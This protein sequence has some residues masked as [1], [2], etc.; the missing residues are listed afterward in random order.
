MTWTAKVGV[1]ALIVALIFG[2]GM[3]AGWMLWHPD[4]A[5][6]TYAPAKV[7]AD[8]SRIL[9]RKPDAEAK[10]PQQIPKGA[11]V[12]RVIYVTV[13]PHGQPAVETPAING[14]DP[15]AARP[16]TYTLGP[17]S[18]SQTPCPPVRFDMTLI[19]LPDQT[20]RVIASSPDGTVL[21]GSM[22]IPVEA[23]APPK[24][25]QW[26]AGGIYGIQSGGGRS[27]GACLDRDIAFLRTGLEVTRDTAPNLPPAWDARVRFMIRF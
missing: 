5:Q 7:Q 14:S 9:E 13:Q 25:L 17:P 1:W 15:Q 3:W 4:L 27:I 18:T 20:R 26:A 6:E 12:E 16:A 22:D 8:G 11:V 24:E 23:A 21:P 2:A 19:R 10:P